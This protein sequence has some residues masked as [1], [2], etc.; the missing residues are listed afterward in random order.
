ML[1]EHLERDISEELSF[2]FNLINL[3]VNLIATCGGG[4]RVGEHSPEMWETQR[5]CSDASAAPH[6]SWNVASHQ[7]PLSLCQ[8]LSALSTR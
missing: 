5:K 8:L 4:Y 7:S 2:K 3:T 6:R 1:V